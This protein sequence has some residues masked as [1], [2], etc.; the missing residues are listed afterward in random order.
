M[1]AIFQ[2]VGKRFN[3]SPYL[4]FKYINIKGAFSQ[5]LQSLRKNYTKL[6]NI[7]SKKKNL[8]LF[9]L[10]IKN[11]SLN[12]PDDRMGEDLNPPKLI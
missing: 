5:I 8:F 4:L 12:Q 6:Q 3:T 7:F 1:R 10:K 9:I 2:L 11:R